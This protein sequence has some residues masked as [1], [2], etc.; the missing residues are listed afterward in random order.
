V[1]VSPNALQ[2]Q[3]SQRLATAF[4]QPSQFTFVFRANTSGMRFT[5][6]TVVFKAVGHCNDLC[7]LYCSVMTLF[8]KCWSAHVRY[9][10]SMSH[11]IHVE[12]TLF[13]AWASP[14]LLCLAGLSDIGPSSSI[15][16]WNHIY[17]A[18]CIVLLTEGQDWP[19]LTPSICQVCLFLQRPFG[20][21]S[22]HLLLTA[23]LMELVL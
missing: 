22:S 3:T 11:F 12:S 21:I 20:G 23:L 10:L 13:V 16:C 2:I 17:C 4:R 19:P 18:P 9:I 7:F 15:D 6:M 8:Q 5:F 1:L 14:Q